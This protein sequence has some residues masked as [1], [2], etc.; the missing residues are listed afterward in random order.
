MVEKSKNSALFISSDP[1]NRFALKSTL[2]ELG[3]EVQCSNTRARARQLLSVIQFNLVVAD[4]EIPKTTGIE[5][6]KILRSDKRNKTLPLVV[7]GE[8]D[9]KSSNCIAALE[10]GA[11]DFIQTPFIT[12]VLKARLNRFL[13]KNTATSNK[14]FLSVQ[15]A[16]GDLPGILQYLE[17]EIKTGKLN[18]KKDDENIA[19]IFFRDGRIV[20]AK[21]PFCIELEAITEVLSWESSHVTFNDA[22]I[23]EEDVKFEREV[24]GTVMNCVVGVDEFHEIQ[25]KMP[26]NDVL[27]KPGNKEI[28]PDKL[29]SLQVKM[30]ELAVKGLSYGDIIA[31]QRVSERKATLLLHEL[32]EEGYLVVGTAPFHDYTRSKYQ[33]Y[34]GSNIYLSRIEEIAKRLT[35]LQ[36]PLPKAKGTNQYGDTDWLATA[37]KIIVTGDSFEHV[38]LLVNSF[39]TIATSISKTKP[40]VRKH[41]KGILT[42]RLSFSRKELIDIQQLPPAFD[43]FILH[44]LSEH[45]SD[46]TSIIFVVSSQDTKTNNENLR[47]MRI[48]RQCFN[49]I[50]FIIVPQVPNTN[51][52]SEFRI[53]CAN[54]KYKL[55]VDMKMAGSMGECPICKTSLIIPDCLDHLAHKFQ[56]PDDVQIAQIQPHLPNH[57]RDLLSMILEDTINACHPPEDLSMSS[58]K[59]HLN[60]KADSDNFRERQDKPSVAV[61]DPTPPIVDFPLPIEKDSPKTP[62]PEKTPEPSP[63]SQTAPVYNKNL[64][65][66]SLND[67]L[68]ANDE[69]FDIDDFISSVRNS[70]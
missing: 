34:K 37:P 46:I 38:S 18:I 66:S 21:A 54:C 65:E 56:I 53:D 20:N 8:D 41:R 35:E 67:I 58:H 39:A 14:S 60:Q 55:A 36:F 4:L 42:T 11:D 69:E 9:E 48:L 30:F 68:N 40:L 3:C 43:K 49:G 63:D 2:E 23:A 31:N 70:P 16:S 47:L 45:M 17:A 51:N 26:P 24:T 7:I 27:F 25:K 29:E 19:E 50:F 62:P 22:E 33:A 15:V 64:N 10:S 57:C 6:C 13:I 12:D 52:V 1:E 5:Y 61:V 28:A 32:I 44:T 59:E